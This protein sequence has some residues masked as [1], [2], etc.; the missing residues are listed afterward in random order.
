MEKISEH[1]IRAKTNC[2]ETIRLVGKR[3]FLIL[4]HF[5]EYQNNLA[6]SSVYDISQQ[7]NYQN[8]STFSFDDYYLNKEDCEANNSLLCIRK[9]EYAD[10]KQIDNI[11]NITFKGTGF[12]RYQVR[13]MVGILIRVG[14]NKISTKEIKNEN[15]ETFQKDKINSTKEGKKLNSQEHYLF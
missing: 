1:I 12:L 2:G 4:T 6:L 11:I 10:I 7:I 8:Y 9:I 15:E 3:I 13:N 14:E 5:G